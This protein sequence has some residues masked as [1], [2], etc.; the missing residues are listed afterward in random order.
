MIKLTLPAKPLELTDALLQELTDSFK[1]DKSKSV[2]KRK[3]I[4]DAVMAIAFGKCCYSECLLGQEGKY[5]EIDH[6]YPKD[7]YPNEVVV[8]GNLLPSNKKCNTTKN[9]HDTKTYPIINPCVD[10][11][12][13]HLY[14]SNYRYYGRTPMGTLTIEVVALNDRE[15]FI[16]R[17][18]EIGNEAQDKLEDLHNTLGQDII[19]IRDVPRTRNRFM[20]KLKRLFKEGSRKEEYAATV[21]TVLLQSPHFDIIKHTLTANGLWDEEL[22]N[23]EDELRFCALMK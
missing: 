6:F 23:L 22:V 11:P 16:N 18:F 5:M 8:W 10:D 2:W 15:H 4:E 12:K 9:D 1:N 13:E 21:S 14:I 19:A 3:V 17:R 7:L 20:G